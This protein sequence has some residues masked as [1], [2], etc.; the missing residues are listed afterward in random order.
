MYIRGATIAGEANK[1]GGI[2]D[3]LSTPENFSGI[4]K[5]RFESGDGRIND[6][7]SLSAKTHNG[8]FK[9]NTNTRTDTIV[10]DISSEMR[11]NMRG[12]TRMKS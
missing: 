6:A 3:R 12:G 10:H 8:A 2:Y 1:K 4:Y 5:R 11:P 7:T 9:G